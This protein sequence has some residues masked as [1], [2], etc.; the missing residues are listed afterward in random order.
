MEKKRIVVLGSTGSIGRQTLEVAAALPERFEVLAICA[1]RNAALLWEQAR[2]FGVP[3][4]GIEDEGAA[5]AKSAFLP[6][7]TTLVA[8]ADAASQLA[9]LPEADIVML[10]IS[11]I[12]ALPALLSA[13]QA[14]KTVAL[15]NKESI[16]CG[17]VLVNRAL[18]AHNGR[19][20]PV[21]SEQSAIFQC[22]HNGSKQDIRQLILTSSGG[23]FWQLPQEEWEHITP[24]QALKHPIWSM[25]EKITIDSATL[26]NKGL[27]VMEASFLFD[28]PKEHIDVLIHPQSIVHSM[29]EYMD[30]TVMAQMSLPDMRLAI[31]Y[32]LTYPERL[33][34]PVKRLSLAEA[35]GLTFF[36][37]KEYPAIR[38]AYDALSEGTILP[39]TYNGANEA[40]VALYLEGRIGFCDIYR[41]V[42]YA[43]EKAERGTIDTLADIMEADARAR[44]LAGEWA[45]HR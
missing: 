8:G 18:K 12:A 35:G 39:I 11:G 31:Q 10:G 42:A 4:V 20:L 26:F 21:D 3:Y 2:V 7:G 33:P 9:A 5:L 32:A 43:M 38:L 14:G 37:A 19:L 34:G 24:K 30:G 27:E 25:G 44:A 28:V 17:N 1:S 15:A 45:K 29:V 40:A 22:M 36:P 13:L 41:S 23:P 6:K 16:V